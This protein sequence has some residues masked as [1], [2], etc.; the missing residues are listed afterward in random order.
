MGPGGL[1]AVH[2][3]LKLKDTCTETFKDNLLYVGENAKEPIVSMLEYE[4][5]RI[6]LGRLS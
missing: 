6:A 5:F 4:A 2:D 1:D 3:I